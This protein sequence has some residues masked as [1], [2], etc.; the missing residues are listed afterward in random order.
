MWAI[1]IVSV[2]ARRRVPRLVAGGEDVVHA[3]D[4]DASPRNFLLAGDPRHLR[5]GHCRWRSDR[6]EVQPR[7]S[8]DA[9]AVCCSDRGDRRGLEVHQHQ[10]CPC[11]LVGLCDDPPA[12]CFHWRFPLPERQSGPEPRHICDELHLPRGDRRFRRVP[13]DPQTRPDTRRVGLRGSD[14][15]SASAA[16]ACPASAPA[17]PAPAAPA[18]RAGSAWTTRLRRGNNS[19]PEPKRPR[20]SLTF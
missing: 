3:L 7:L 20:G 18:A 11:V 9:S 19:S 17:S 15:P 14:P 16:P 2:G 1:T 8:D 12:W 5:H 10:R 6:R 4:P 13:T